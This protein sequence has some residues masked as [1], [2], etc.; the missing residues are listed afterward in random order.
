MALT[1]IASVCY[2]PLRKENK[3]QNNASLAIILL[4]HLNNPL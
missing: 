3:E 1:Q 4:L 2:E